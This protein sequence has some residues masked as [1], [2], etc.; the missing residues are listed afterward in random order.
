MKI[1]FLKGTTLAGG[2]PVN[3]GEVHD[4]SADDAYRFAHIFRDAEYVKDEAPQV[5]ATIAE[6]APAEEVPI[7]EPKKG[8]KVL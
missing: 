8:K 7:V 6:T 3:P 2:I 1:K 5:A 4:V